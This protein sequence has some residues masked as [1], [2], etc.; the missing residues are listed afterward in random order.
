MD[1]KNA[2]IQWVQ[3]ENKSTNPTETPT[4]TYSYIFVKN[5]ALYLK[6]DDNT[7]IGPLGPQKLD[8]SDVSNPPTDAELDSAFGT[9]ATV[10]S[11]FTAFVD[12]NNADTAVYFVFTNGTSWWYTAMT[13]AV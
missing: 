2:L 12:D 6:L 1:I 5:D 11:G 4:S 7:I 10:G 13:K 3:T 9:P 8:V